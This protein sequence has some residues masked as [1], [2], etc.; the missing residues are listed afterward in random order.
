MMKTSELLKITPES[1]AKEQFDALKKALLSKLSVFITKIQNNKWKEANKSLSFSPAGD[2]MGVENDYIGCEDL[3]GEPM[4][5]V[6][7]VLDR[8][9]KLEGMS[10]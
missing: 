1:L 2:D 8:L 5:D 6:G 3:L 9:E 10:K 7:D 4:S